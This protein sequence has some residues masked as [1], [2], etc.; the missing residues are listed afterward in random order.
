MQNAT[1]EFLHGCNVWIHAGFKAGHAGVK[2]MMSGLL[3]SEIDLC[4][5]TVC[6]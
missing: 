6:K 2:K 3:D 4:G 5:V 1:L